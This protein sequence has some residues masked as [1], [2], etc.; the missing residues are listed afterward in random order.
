MSSL[1]LYPVCS[2][3]TVAFIYRN[4]YLSAFL[5]RNFLFIHILGRIILR[6][7]PPPNVSA[8]VCLFEPHPGQQF[9]GWR[10]N[11]FPPACSASAFVPRH[12]LHFPPHSPKQRLPVSLI[13][14]PSFRPSPCHLLAPLRNDQQAFPGHAKAV[15][16]KLL[17]IGNL[18]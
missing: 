2:A 9:E 17:A 18:E 6:L 16:W 15:A 11:I 10:S 7:L 3:L 4:F 5:Y 13:C 8:P 14:I 1:Q 12:R